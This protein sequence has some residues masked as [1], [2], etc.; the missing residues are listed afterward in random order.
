M[1]KSRI[2]SLRDALSHYRSRAGGTVPAGPS[3]LAKIKESIKEAYLTGK[4]SS[5]FFDKCRS[6]I[7]KTSFVFV[8]D[9][10][11]VNLIFSICS[12]AAD[13]QRSPIVVSGTRTLSGFYQ[14]SVYPPGWSKHGHIHIQ[15]S[16]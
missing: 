6:N 11:T 1:S 8:I 3:L 15:W 10:L 16:R 13:R 5:A 14:L 2:D 9:I 7:G 4:C 12:Q